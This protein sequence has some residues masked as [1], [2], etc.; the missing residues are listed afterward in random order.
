MQVVDLRRA[1]VQRKSNAGI[2]IAF[3]FL[4]VAGVVYLTW[5]DSGCVS[6]GVMTWGGKMCV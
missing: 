4:F 1:R 3:V 6:N 5:L 2:V